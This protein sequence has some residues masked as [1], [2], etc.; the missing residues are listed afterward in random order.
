M[1][2]R[3]HSRLFLPVSLAPVAAASRPERG[4]GVLR[5]LR[6]FSAL[7]I[8]THPS[9]R[10]KSAKRGIPLP[11]SIFDLLFFVILSASFCAKDLNCSNLHQPILSSPPDQNERSLRSFSISSSYFLFSVFCH[12]DRRDPVFSC[13]PSFGAPGLGVEGSW[14][15]VTLA[16]SDG[17]SSALHS[18]H[19]PAPPL[20]ISLAPAALR[21]NEA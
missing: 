7:G 5:P 9:F 4:D 13:A 15:A 17:I 8:R 21:R 2:H 11:I 16:Q 20:K 1:T 19:P 14:L 6:R 12:P 10:A 3:H 18:A